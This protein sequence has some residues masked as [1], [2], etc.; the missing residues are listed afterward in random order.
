MAGITLPSKIAK[1]LSSAVERSPRELADAALWLYS[2]GFEE[3]QRQVGAECSDR[4]VLLGALWEHC[5]ALVEL[6]C[7][8]WPAGGGRR[9]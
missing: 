3:L 7:A 5:F 2:V 9:N 8:R 1:G 6:R 4:A